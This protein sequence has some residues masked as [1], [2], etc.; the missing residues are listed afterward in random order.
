M[1][2]TVMA[3]IA[4]GMLAGAGLA[5]LARE[6]SPEHPRLSDAMSNLAPAPSTTRPGP[7][8][9]APAGTERLGAWAESTLTRLPGVST[10]DVD[11]RLIGRTGRW[12]WAQKLSCVLIGLII[13]STAGIL[14]SLLGV[15]LPIAVPAGLGLLVAAA[16]WFVPDGYVRTEAAR[17]RSDFASAAVSYLR[18]VA[19]KRLGGRG[20]VE[21]LTSA[22]A[23]SDAWVFVRIREELAMAD[24][25]GLT[26]WA[27]LDRVA[28][29]IA[30]PE[31]HEIA[32]IARLS[33][34]G[35][36]IS[37][38]LL[39]RASSMRDRILSREHTAAAAAT[40]SLAVPLAVLLYLFVAALLYPMV[41]ILLS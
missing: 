16:M 9:P 7:A 13:P 37:D 27:A 40:T 38:N 18:L 4:L 32:D 26:P 36:A 20:V 35:S 15:G 1:S 6:F 21:S 3:V 19:I 39:A 22:A 34:Q 17:A 41:I 10:P 33:E 28:D 2:P 23:L 24:M 25:A 5:L 12:F 14:A 11:L 8:L 30:V 29:E 31:L